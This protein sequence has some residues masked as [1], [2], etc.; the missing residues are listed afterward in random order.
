MAV[1]TIEDT[2]VM[3]GVILSG[4]LGVLETRCEFSFCINKYIFTGCFQYAYTL[5]WIIFSQVKN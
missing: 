1:A 5:D 2:E 4:N 3:S